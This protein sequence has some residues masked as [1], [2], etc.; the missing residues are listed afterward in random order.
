[1]PSFQRTDKLRLSYEFD[2]FTDPWQERPFLLLQH[3]NGRNARFWYR[4]IPYLARHFRI[5][6]PDM[7]GLGESTGALDLEQDISLEALIGDLL[8]VWGE[9]PPIPPSLRRAPKRSVGATQQPINPLRHLPGL[10]P[11][12]MPESQTQSRDSKNTLSGMGPKSSLGRG[13]FF[14]WQ[15]S[16]QSPTMDCF[17]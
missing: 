17:A 5:I 6:R 2:D 15:K 8:A 12:S 11:G 3:G 1:M 7:R 9:A 13:V 14:G 10:D 4:W 16:Q